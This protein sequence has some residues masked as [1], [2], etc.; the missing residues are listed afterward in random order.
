[1]VG[2]TGGEKNLVL[3]NGEKNFPVLKNGAKNW[4]EKTFFRIRSRGS[5][6]AHDG[7]QEA[8]FS[9]QLPVLEIW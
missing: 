3:K 8:L 2:K 1:M 5:A 6:L 4:W 9:V 7:R